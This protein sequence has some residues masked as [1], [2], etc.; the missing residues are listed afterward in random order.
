MSTATKFSDIPRSSDNF[1]DSGAIELYLLH[2]NFS[3]GEAV[4]RSKQIDSFGDLIYACC[5]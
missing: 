5:R 4:H 2:S 1:P 3:A